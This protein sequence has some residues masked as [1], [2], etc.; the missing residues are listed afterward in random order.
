MLHCFCQEFGIGT[1]HSVMPVKN[2]KT[3]FFKLRF[4]LLLSY[5]PNKCFLQ[6]FGID[7]MHIL[8]IMYVLYT[9][10]C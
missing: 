9:G 7:I 10:V 1:M 3:C 8:D 2:T 5:D 4:S 6:E